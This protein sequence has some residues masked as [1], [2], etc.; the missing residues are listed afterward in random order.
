M[1]T[2]SK[3]SPYS[4]TPLNN[5]SYLDV[6]TF[7][8]I[9][10]QVSDVPWEI[11]PPYMHRPDLLAFDLYGDVSYWWVFAVRNK[12]VIKDPVYDLIPGVTIYLPQA[13]TLRTALG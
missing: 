11:T 1:T 9:P 6:M 8:D 13:D 10:A 7:R 12:N 4:K 5:G 3:N 2:Y